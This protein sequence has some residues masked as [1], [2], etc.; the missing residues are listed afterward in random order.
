[1]SV[2][3]RG[4]PLLILNGLGGRLGLLDRLRVELSDFQTIAF[5]SPG[6]G[7]SP[8]PEIQAR[9]MFRLRHH[10][11]LARAVLCYLG[12]TKTVSV[13]GISLGGAVAQELAHRQPDLV[14]KLVL[15]ST[16]SIPYVVTVPSA[17]LAFFDLRRSLSDEAFLRS[18][19]L[20]YGGL[21]RRN[22]EL[23]A[24]LRP[25]F[26]PVYSRSRL[27]QLFAACMWTSLDFAHLIR[28]PTLL[29]TG[30]DDPLIPAYNS[31]I[32]KALIPNAQLE[33]FAG[34][35][36]LLVATSPEETALAVRRFLL[37]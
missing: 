24:A 13:M 32:L 6:I 17:Y 3:G 5:D 20:L 34:E 23:I 30:D 31:R 26:E 27:R 9:R 11:D 4:Q 18:A 29:L 14:Q 15:A 35:G 33:V 37:A 36:H 25:H 1:M 8:P 10:A 22:P 2:R 28:Q 19:P 21:I 7:E 12:H 16:T